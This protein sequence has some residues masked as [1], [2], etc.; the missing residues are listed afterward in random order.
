MQITL[1]CYLMPKTN[2]HTES[3]TLRHVP[4]ADGSCCNKPTSGLLISVNC[5]AGKYSNRVSKW[6]QNAA[7]QFR[8]NWRGGCCCS[9][10]RGQKGVGVYKGWESEEEQEEWMRIF[11]VFLFSLF[12]SFE[13]RRRT[14]STRF[15]RMTLRDR[16]APPPPFYGVT[17]TNRTRPLNHHFCYYNN[18]PTPE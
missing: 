13:K 7:R 17:N 5:Q 1:K 4:S 2:T 12:Y 8:D 16:L 3:L 10:E 9:F 6:K 15:A 11:Y 14:R 18:I